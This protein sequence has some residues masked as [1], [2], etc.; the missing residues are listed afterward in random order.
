MRYN[1]FQFGQTASTND[2]ITEN[3]DCTQCE[4]MKDYGACTCDPDM[5]TAM[6]PNSEGCTFVLGN[7][8][9]PAQN[10]K[11]AWMEYAT[12]N[13]VKVA[14]GTIEAKRK[15]AAARAAKKAMPNEQSLFRSDHADPC[16]GL[17]P[18]PHCHNPLR[19][20]KK[21]SPDDTSDYCLSLLTQVSQDAFDCTANPERPGCEVY[22]QTT[23]RFQ[24][25]VMHHSVGST[26][27]EHVFEQERNTIFKQS[28][29]M[30]T[31][32]GSSGPNDCLF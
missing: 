26:P 8:N 11:P 16:D 21:C 31:C 24:E 1:R 30:P 2:P 3:K 7:E 19:Q 9:S 22:G 29:E 17:N 20:D 13:T 6:P 15:S 10:S 4:D 23:Y 27:G 18:A 28:A 5:S 32:V 14:E 25:N 12:S